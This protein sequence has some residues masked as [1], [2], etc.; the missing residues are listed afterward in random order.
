MTLLLQR[1]V[2]VGERTPYR[3]ALLPISPSI[4]PTTLPTMWLLSILILSMLLLSG[5]DSDTPKAPVNAD[6]ENT[7]AAFD[8]NLDQAT[9]AAWS[10][11]QTQAQAATTAS[12]QMRQSILHMLATPSEQ[13]LTAAQTSWHTAHN[14]YHQLSGFITIAASNPG[15]FGEL[16]NTTTRLDAHPIMPGYLDSVSGYPY[17][18]LVNDISAKLDAKQVRQQHFL[19]D[20]S[21]VSL[22]F[23]AIEFLLWGE[24][25]QRPYSDFTAK[26][27]LTDAQREQGFERIQLPSNRRRTLLRLQVELLIDDIERLTK[28][29][30][31]NGSLHQRYQRL[32]A[33]SRVTLMRRASRQLLQHMLANLRPQT[34]HNEFAQQEMRVSQAQLQGLRDWLFD[35]P[36]I[37]AQLFDEPE[38]WQQQL[39][40]SIDQFNQ[41]EAQPAD[42]TLVLQKLLEG[43]SPTPK[44][45]TMLD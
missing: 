36:H 37:P 24:N 30:Q 31:T 8:P 28:Q 5:C 13:S 18:G 11:S 29:L 6:P 25:G 9:L 22:G 7:L 2:R 1:T 19:T 17:S 14:Q 3:G 38:H 21:E 34:A 41:L 4:S 12:K 23:H 10:V 39:E 40:A 20:D 43:L 33:D 32:P 26:N 15:L 44:E 27:T 35:S 45:H 42:I 16:S